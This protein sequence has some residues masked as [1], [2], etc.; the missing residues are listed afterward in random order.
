MWD[1][2]TAVL[3]VAVVA[4]GALVLPPIARGA[5]GLLAVIGLFGVMAGSTWAPTVAAL[6][7]VAWLVGHWS[8]AARHD[9]RYRSR[10]ARALFDETPLRWTLPQYHARRRRRELAT[11]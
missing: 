7:A 3:A 5:G 8:F 4:S 9:A 2:G 1:L 11:R 6:G 10:L